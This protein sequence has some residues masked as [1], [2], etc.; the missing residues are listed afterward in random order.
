M[1]GALARGF[2]ASGLAAGAITIVEPGAEKCR[3]FAAEGFSVA[4][5]LDALSASYQPDVTLLA[6]KPQ[7]FDTLAPALSAFYQ[8]RPA[9]LFLSILAGTTLARLASAL[10]ADA[11]IVRVMPNTPALIGEGVSACIASASV[12]GEQRVSTTSLLSSVGSVVWLDDE[13]QIDVATA[14]SGSGPAYMFHV[15][16]CLID[17]ATARGLPE[18][19]ARGLAIAT[20]RGSSGLALQSP[21]P[22]NALRKNV[23]SPGGTT[24]AALSVLMPALPALFAEAADAA[25][26]RAKALA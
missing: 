10:G 1:G 16:E 21:A 8:A 26:A 20:M 25:I 13:S 5:S 22:L 7:G 12:S 3:D 17:A 15:L 24:E 19:V 2:R 11:P 14:I 6:I 9:H 18:D 4:T 23:T